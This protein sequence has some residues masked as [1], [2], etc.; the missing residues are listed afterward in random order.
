M[1]K[2]IKYHLICHLNAY[3]HN[4]ARKSQV[5]CRLCWT[6]TKQLLFYNSHSQRN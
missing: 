1:Q 4:M 5:L 3:F 2:T 6:V